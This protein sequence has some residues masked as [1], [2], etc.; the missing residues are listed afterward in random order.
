MTTRKNIQDYEISDEDWMKIEPL[1]PLPKP[2]KKHG[3]PRKDNKRIFSGIFY[4]LRTGCQ[5]KALPRFYGAQSTAH[6]RFQ[7]WQ[8]S[9]FFENLWMAG[10][11][12]YNFEKG[13]EWE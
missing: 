3:R 6:D 1:L 12:E 4:L 2:K 9:G 8:R 5:W 10:L 13:L 11:V 7:E